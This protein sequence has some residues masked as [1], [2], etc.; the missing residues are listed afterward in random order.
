MMYRIVPPAVGCGVGHWG[1]LLGSV[2]PAQ[3]RGDQRELIEIPPVVALG[4]EELGGMSLSAL[5]L[6]TRRS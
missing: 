4:P 2:L 5:S 6:L 3:A 1:R